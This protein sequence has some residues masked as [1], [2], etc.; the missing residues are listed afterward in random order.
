[1]RRRRVI[2]VQISW[3]CKQPM[4]SRLYSDGTSRFQRVPHDRWL[5]TWHRFRRWHRDSQTLS[6]CDIPYLTGPAMD[7]TRRIS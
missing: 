7:L 3:V 6:I 2:R 4:I 5:R 1:M